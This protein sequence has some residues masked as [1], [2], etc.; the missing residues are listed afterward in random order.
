MSSSKPPLN[1]PP[2]LAAPFEAWCIHQRQRGR[3]RREASITVYRAMWLALAEWCALQDPGLPLQALDASR[4]QR[5]LESRQ[6]MAGPGQ[7]LT[8]RYRLRLLSLVRWVQAHDLA[9]KDPLAVAIS[10][11]HPLHSRRSAAAL[12]WSAAHL[13]AQPGVANAVADAPGSLGAEAAETLIGWL[14]G[15]LPSGQA[16]APAPRRW[17][18]ARDHAALALLLG[19]GIGPGDLRA[20]RLADVL[21]A[22]DPAGWVSPVSPVSPV[23]LADPAD[24]VVQVGPGNTAA[25]PPA[26]GWQLTVPGNGNAPAYRARVAAW[27][28]PLLRHW[29]AQRLGQQIPGQWLFPSTRSGKPWGKVA[30]YESVRRC[31]AEAGL[32][33]APGGSFRLRHSFALRQLVHGHDADSVAAWLGVSDPAVMLRYRH[34]LGAALIDHAAHGA[35]QAQGSAPATATASATAG[36][37]NPAPPWPI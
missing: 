36:D 17:Q 8:P 18:I 4:L 12:A 37:A 10:P 24:P 35:H 5:Y 33:D 13:A 21:P 14:Q 3:L 7:A 23:D 25:P 16:P 19:A 30:Q 6:G 26:T 32:A 2:A 29:L 9:S 28:A 31:L 1:S 15:G 22:H 11:S 34:A 20:L 27:A